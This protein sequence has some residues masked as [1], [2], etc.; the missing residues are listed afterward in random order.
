MGLDCIWKPPKPIEGEPDTL[1][2]GAQIKVE[3]PRFEP[4]LQ[5]II[6]GSHAIPMLLGDIEKGNPGPPS[7]RGKV[8]VGMIEALCGIS[9]YGDD[10]T[11]EVSNKE[12]LIVAEALEVL[13]AS[14]LPYSEHN[15]YPREEIHDL[16]RMFRGYGN[17]GAYIW[18]WS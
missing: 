14:M 16:A 4:P 1:P 12:V 13:F 9:L 10:D 5:H 2:S 3:P 11:H 15:G 18:A 17:A 7:F 8:Y 6:G